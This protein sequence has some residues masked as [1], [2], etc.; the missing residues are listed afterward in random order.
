MAPN[1]V[2]TIFILRPH[3]QFTFSIRSTITVY[4][5]FWPTQPAVMIAHPRH[6]SSE[7]CLLFLFFSCTSCSAHCPRRRLLRSSPSPSGKPG[8]QTLHISF[9]FNHQGH[10]TPENESIE[11]T[12][13]LQVLMSSHSFSSGYT[14]EYL[15]CARDFSSVFMF[16]LVIG[17]GTA[18]FGGDSL[19]LA[20]SS[21]W[22]SFDLRSI[23]WRCVGGALRN[24]HAQWNDS[25]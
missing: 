2:S 25:E 16:E 11:T 12:W 24:G 17:F 3:L 18:L 4:A 7:T 15:S 20:P 19:R 6:R 9:S 10:Q 13:E 23:G 22:S 14:Q 5:C 21:S 8:P 1:S